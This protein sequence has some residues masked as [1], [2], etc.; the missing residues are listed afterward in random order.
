MRRIGAVHSSRPGVTSQTNRRGA[1]PP[2]AYSVI[3]P[4]TGEAIPDNVVRALL[5]HKLGHARHELVE[6]DQTRLVCVDL[7][8]YSVKFLQRV[9]ETTQGRMSDNTTTHVPP[10]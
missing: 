4:I 1:I 5:Q 7:L 6:V 3:A 9:T 8:K 10:E 2:E